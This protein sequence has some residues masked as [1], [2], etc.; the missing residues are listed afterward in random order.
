MGL[1]S[2][3]GSTPKRREQDSRNFTSA[4]LLF[5]AVRKAVRYIVCRAP[6]KGTC[7]AAAKSR[8][9]R[10]TWSLLIR[11]TPAPYSIL[12]RLRFTRQDD[13]D[14]DVNF[15]SGVNRILCGAA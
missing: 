11:F 13:I 10:I 14:K 8:I 4:L 6:D 7:P 15:V 5:H 3:E 2:A 1:L 12:Y 9:R